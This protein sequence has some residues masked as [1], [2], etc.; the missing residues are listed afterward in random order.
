MKTLS[1]AVS[2]ARHFGVL[3]DDD[4][5]IDNITLDKRVDTFTSALA[6]SKDR[7]VSLNQFL[8][9]GIEQANRTFSFN[10]LQVPH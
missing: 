2:G 7:D 3:V 6:L 9:E 4:Q 1:F 5:V 10:S 8:K